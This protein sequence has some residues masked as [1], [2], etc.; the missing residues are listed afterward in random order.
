MKLAVNIES[1]RQ[2]DD[3]L[4]TMDFGGLP[5]LPFQ[6][7]GIE[8]MV[9]QLMTRKA[10]AVM[11]ADE[12]GLGKTIQALGV[13]NLLGAKRLLVVCPASLRLNW[14]REIEKWHVHNPGV[15]T[16]INGKMSNKPICHSYVTSYEL[17]AKCLELEPELIIIDEAHYLKNPHTKRVKSIL[18]TNRKRG[19]IK[20]PT[21]FLTGTP[22]LN[23]PID[24]WP[25]LHHTAPGI[26]D[27]MDYWT[28]ARRF[29]FI[30][31]D[32]WGTTV[33]KG[34]Q[35]QPELRTRLRGSGFMVR[36]FK[37]EVIEYLPEKAYKIIEFSADNA[38][39]KILEKEEK[40]K[41]EHLH[42]ISTNS[43]LAKIRQEIGLAKLPKCLKYIKELL[44]SG[45]EKLVVFAHHISVIKKL[46]T[47]LHKYSPVVIIGA[48][49]MA[50]RQQRVDAF[51]AN[52][53]NRV[54][55][56]NIRAAGVGVTLTA[57]C[58]VIMV[59][60]SW[61]PSENEQCIDR[62]HRIGQSRGVVV[63]YLI[64]KDSIDATVLRVAA[65]KRKEI[66]PA[67]N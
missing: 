30:S 65:R 63:H 16:H 46:E 67:L 26:I 55:I 50:M 44:D 53:V 61:V 2:R 23:S 14:T 15:V 29:C 7:A 52:A 56:G 9:D 38:L 3:S 18:G 36:R 32:N 21:I 20:T 5:Y 19:I 43:E 13:A 60:A 8:H 33:A 11:C 39:S 47:S 34:A 25:I 4:C 6:K 28:F 35:R 51:Q 45:T 22:M 27:N 57:A 10:Q 31:E 59:E 12:P 37:K 42:G 17:V 54:L 49:P 62:L 40:F 41:T 1:S 64:V 24:L 66:E 48:T 58:D